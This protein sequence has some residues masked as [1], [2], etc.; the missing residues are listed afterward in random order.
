VVVV[1]S[2]GVLRLDFDCL[3]QRFDAHELLPGADGII[4]CFLRVVGHLGSKGLE[5]L[6]DLTTRVHGSVK[7][8]LGHLLIVFTDIFKLLHHRGLPLT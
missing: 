1:N 5:A 2:L 3:F 7:A 4:E 6:I 8:T